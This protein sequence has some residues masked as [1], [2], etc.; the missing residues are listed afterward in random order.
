MPKR[1]V[2]QVS[3][4]ALTNHRIPARAGEPVPPVPQKQFD[5][6]VVVNAPPGRSVQLS[7]LTLLRAYGQLSIQNPEYGSRFSNLLDELSRTQPQDPF[8]QSALGH[9][10]L[11][12]DKPEEA[13][14]HLKAALALDDATVNL[15]MG[16]ALAKLGRY[17]E[18]IEYTKKAVDLAPYDAVMQKTLILQYINIKDY[19]EARQLM[20]RYIAAFPEDSFMRSLLA[21][22][23]P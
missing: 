19:G 23:K 21:K 8:V 15:E 9:K 17:E 4:S 2:Q 16:E 18:A 6:L 7:K 12:E 11:L 10:A 3:H 22:V 20:E 5:G 13:I 14:A 1:S